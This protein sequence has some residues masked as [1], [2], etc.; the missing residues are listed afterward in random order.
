MTPAHL[1]W[2]ML[3][4]HRSRCR[5]SITH[6]KLG[7]REVNVNKGGGYL[8]TRSRMIQH[9]PNVRPVCKLLYAKSHMTLM[10]NRIR[11]DSPKAGVWTCILLRNHLADRQIR[12][13]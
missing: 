7:R 4:L 6:V 5:E 1:L 8:T 11:L 12:G 3:D 13:K 10:L 9:A 2:A